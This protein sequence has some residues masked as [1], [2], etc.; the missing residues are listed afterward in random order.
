MFLYLVNNHLSKPWFLLLMIIINFLGS[1]YG[2]YW[3]KDQLEETWPVLLRIVVPD[4]PTGSS[5]FT[6]FLIA[7]LMRKK[8]PTLEAFAAI[9]NFKYGVWAVTVILGGWSFGGDQHWT[10]YMLMGSHGGMAIESLLYARYYSFKLR[11]VM[12][13]AVWTLAND[14]FDYLWNVHPWLPSNLNPY[15]TTIGWFTVLLSL[16]SLTIFYFLTGRSK[17]K[18]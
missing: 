1:I 17:K 7:L 13:V 14:Y 8:L 11:H 6:L 12:I 16:F 4:S 18:V 3:Y 9:T 2:F 15:T 5:L 10:D